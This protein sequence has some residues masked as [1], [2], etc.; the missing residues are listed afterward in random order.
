[1]SRK[2]VK[3]QVAIESGAWYDCSNNDRN[4]Y[5]APFHIRLRVLSFEEVYLTM[6]GEQLEIDEEGKL[7]FSDIEIVNLNKKR[8]TTG[9]INKHLILIDQN[10][11]EYNKLYDPFDHPIMNFAYQIGAERLSV[12]GT[13]LFPKIKISGRI[14]FFL[15]D[16]EDSE[17]FIKIKNGTIIEA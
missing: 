10:G 3:I 9:D 13:A 14:F 16:D 7:F 6:K 2:Y 12:L 15:P 17:Y 8:M 11:Y 4:E 5:D 1:M